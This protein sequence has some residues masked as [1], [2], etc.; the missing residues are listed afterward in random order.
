MSTVRH[1]LVGLAFC[2]AIGGA[3]GP[4]AAQ[5]AEPAHHILSTPENVVW[6]WFPDRP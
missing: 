5:P 1:G 4:A 6:G 3:P 2:A